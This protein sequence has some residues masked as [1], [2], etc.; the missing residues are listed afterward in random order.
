M[1]PEPDGAGESA[2]RSLYLHFPFCAHRCHYCDF[3]VRAAARPPVSEWLEAV[4]AEIRTRFRRRGWER[5]APLETVY[6]G[7]GTPSLLGADGMLQVA[8]MLRRHFKVAPDAE[9]SAEANPDSLSPEVA[10]SWREAGVTRV[11]LGVQSFQEP[12]LAWLGRLHG[13]DAAVRAVE[14]AAGT[15]PAVNVDLLFGLPAGVPRDWSRDV[16][17]CAELGVEHVSSYGL[18]AGEGT[19]LGRW[20]REGKVR[21]AGEDR[22]GEEYL[23]AS[24]RLREAGYEHYE[25]SHFALPGRRC[26]HQER[27]WTGRPYLGV[28]PSAHSWLPPVRLWNEFRWQAYR[29]A[30]RERGE[31]AAGSEEPD[32]AARLLERLWLVLRRDAGLEP[33]TDLARRVRRQAAGV[34]GSWERA[35]WARPSDGGLSLTPE[36]WLRL[37]A[38]VTELAAKLEYPAADGLAPES[39]RAGARRG[40]DRDRPPPEPG[41]RHFTN[42]G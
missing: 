12:A 21:L 33:G 41:A 11:S 19:P 37:D 22:Y 16:A 38:L 34:P 27:G 18:A 36:G 14:L 4:E 39:G 32:G 10:R 40:R 29:E 13:P 24:R 30:V 26:R 2:P 6:V 1:G 23:L 20:E 17:R 3:S 42:E 7:G 25:V 5:P 31:A 15:F 9:W 35:G 8:E 28:G